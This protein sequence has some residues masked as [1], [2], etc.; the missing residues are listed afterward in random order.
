MQILLANGVWEPVKLPY[1]R[2]PY[3]LTSRAPYEALKN[4]TDIRRLMLRRPPAIE[5]L[6]EEEAMKIFEQA[7]REQGLWVLDDDGEP[8]RDDNGKKTPDTEAALEEALEEQR[9]L[10]LGKIPG[11]EEEPL[12]DPATNK[13]NLGERMTYGRDD[14]K[15]E[16]PRALTDDDIITPKVMGI[17]RQVAHDIPAKEKKPAKQV[18][19][20]L[21][22]IPN[23]SMD[24]YEY[25]RSKGH[26]TSVKNWANKMQ[27]KLISEAEDDSNDDEE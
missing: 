11:Q 26:Y 2:S 20:E 24:D 5:L 25:I 16:E 18:I 4:S 23:L 19:A 15:P 22:L 14:V 27:E 10:M 1:N 21:K 7:A 17:L 13:I 9:A 12:W 6:T 8:A 3:N